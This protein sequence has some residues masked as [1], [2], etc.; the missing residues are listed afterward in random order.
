M[1]ESKQHRITGEMTWKTQY[2]SNSTDKTRKKSTKEM[3]KPQQRGT[4]KIENE[5]SEGKALL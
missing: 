1:Q 5:K 4:W 2:P 3:E